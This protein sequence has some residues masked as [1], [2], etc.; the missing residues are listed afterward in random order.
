LAKEIKP[1]FIFLEN[2]P[3]ITTRGGLQI[4]REITEM[5][6]D[7]RWCVISAQSIGALHKR[8]RWFLLAHSKHN[9]APTCE[10]GGSLGKVKET[11][12]QHEHTESIGQ[13][14]RTS[15]LSGDVASCDTYSE[16]SKQANTQAK[17][18]ETEQDPRRGYTRQHWPLES[19]E[20]W[21]ET[22]SS[23]GKCSDGV[24]NHVDRLRALGNSV[25]PEQVRQAFEYLMGIS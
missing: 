11:R 18:Y 1:K 4:V 5:G 23:M 17:P 14:Q 6:Y 2:V 8:E 25:V 13:T 19:R 12:Q 10:N 22:V 7:C 3:A 16:P 24:Q 21:Q 15:S 20:H 9:G